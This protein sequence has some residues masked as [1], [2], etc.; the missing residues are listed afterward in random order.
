MHSHCL[1]FCHH[2]LASKLQLCA[3]NTL[4]KCFARSLQA[5]SAWPLP[6]SC[7][8]C[9]LNTLLNVLHALCE[10][11]AHGHCPAVYNHVL[12]IPYQNVLRALCRLSAHGHCPAVRH[13]PLATPDR[14]GYY[15]RLGPCTLTALRCRCG[16]TSHMFFRLYALKHSASCKRGGVWC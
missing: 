9:A 11:S 13:H 1:S 2:P 10:L 5:V 4:S 15:V 14:Q 8:P 16:R 3:L 6:C 12:S 7:K